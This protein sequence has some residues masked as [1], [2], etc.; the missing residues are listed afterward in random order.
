MV[1]TGKIGLQQWKR[2][3]R[4][5][6]NEIWKF[7]KNRLN[8]RKI[9]FKWLFCIKDD[10]KHKTRLFARVFEQEYSIDYHET[11]AP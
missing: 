6:K 8:M 7:I 10:G 9:S 1:L 3:K 4:T 2:R 11:Y 5:T